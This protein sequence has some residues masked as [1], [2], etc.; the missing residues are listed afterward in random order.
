MTF[1]G[2]SRYWANRT[3]S[4]ADIADIVERRI[5]AIAE[6]VA[7]GEPKQAFDGFLAEMRASIDTSITP[8]HA[9][10]LLAQHSITAPVFDALFEDYAFAGKNTISAA[11]GQMTDVLRDKGGLDENFEELQSFCK[12]FTER[13]A[14]ITGTEARQKIIIELY[15]DFF[16]TAFPKLTDRLGIVYTPIEV[17]DFIINSV[18]D[19]L[20]AEFGRKLTDEN[21]RI[22]DP[23]TG[24]GTFITR[25]LQSGLI[26]KTDLTR[27]YK[28]EIF[29]NELVL[30]AYHIACVNIENAYHDALGQKEYIPFGG[31]TLADTFQAWESNPHELFP[32]NENA[33]DISRQ[34]KPPITLILGN[35][36]YS[37]G[38]KSANDNAGNKSY[39]RIDEAIAGTYAAKSN[40]LAKRSLYD[41]YMRAFRFATD[42]LGG[43]DGIVCFVTNGA[44]LDGNAAVG[45]RKSIEIEYNK[46]FVYK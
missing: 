32:L 9:I 28:R 7:N 17:V 27:K 37:V 22:F 19:V 38:Q 2:N 44:W 42:L 15:N 39:P 35:P 45:F 40:A 36:P 29:A 46:C 11:L 33:E 1:D 23:F 12:S 3:C 41:S 21:V 43:G 5:A 16:K 6:I 4:V 24:T 30:L 34:N 31:L 13:I 26:S 8:D 18:S 20:H 25:L 10:E 14:E